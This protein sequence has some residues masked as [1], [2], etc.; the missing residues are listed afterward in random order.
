[1][2]AAGTVDVR[3]ARSRRADEIDLLDQRAARVLQAEQNHFR[4]DIIQV[5]R[6]ERAGKARLGLVVIADADEIDVARA[7][8][9]PAREEKHV[10]AALAGAV[11]QFAPTVGE[12]IVPPAAKQRDA[13]PP[14]ATR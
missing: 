5:G 3:R 12:D 2:R 7:I 4:H 13:R 1:D 8:D 10:D 14:A 11:E 9:L 6:A